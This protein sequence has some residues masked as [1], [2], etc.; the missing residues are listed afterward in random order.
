MG[1]QLRMPLLPR[2]AEMVSE[3]LAVASDD[4]RITFFDASGPIFTCRG[5]KLRLV[6]EAAQAP[7]ESR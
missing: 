3:Q 4:G 2:N 5:T 1:L 7:P 6:L